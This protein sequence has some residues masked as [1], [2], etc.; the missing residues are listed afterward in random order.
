M[1]HAFDMACKVIEA[2]IALCL[3]IMVVLV[4]GNVVLRYGFN[5]GITISEE[6]SRWLFIWLT[7]LGAVVA[8]RERSHLGADIVVQRLPRNGRKACLIVG[9]L[10][11]LFIVALMFKGSL[12]QAIINWDN[13]APTTGLPMSVIYIPGVMFSVLAAPILLRDLYRASFGNLE[14]HELIGVQESEEGAQFKDLKDG[15]STIP[16]TPT[17]PKGRQE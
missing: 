16:I 11:M 1:N 10:L 6:I 14:D 8:V 15:Q 4:F 3:A 17:E 7:F 2:F 13:A 12:D 5:L 9:H